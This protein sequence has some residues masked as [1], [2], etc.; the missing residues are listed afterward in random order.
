MKNESHQI[1]KKLKLEGM[2]S[3]YEGVLE[4][5]VN[6]Q[7]D[8][9]ELIARLADAEKQYRS[10]RRTKMFLRLSKLRYPAN[11][12]DIECSKEKFNQRKV[13]NTI[14]LFLLGSRRKHLTHWINWL[15]KII[16]SMCSRKS[17]MHAWLSNAIL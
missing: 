9:H 1:L 5:P 16:L 13:S 11:L 14:R 4:L 7:P 10:D 6:Q 15:W 12:S 8:A 17:R 2:A 3:A